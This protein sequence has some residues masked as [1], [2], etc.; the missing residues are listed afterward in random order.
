M[1]IWVFNCNFSVSYLS[2]FKRCCFCNCFFCSRFSVRLRFFFSRRWVFFFVCLICRFIIYVR[3]LFLFVREG[4]LWLLVDLNRSEG[5]YL[6]LVFEGGSFFFSFI[7]I[8]MFL[9]YRFV[10]SMAFFVS[11]RCFCNFLSFKSD[12]Y[13]SLVRLSFLS[14]FLIFLV[15]LRSF[16]WFL[17]DFR[18]FLAILI[19]FVIIVFWRDNLFLVFFFWK[20]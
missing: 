8:L 3:F 9:R 7:K 20:F 11:V 15:S 10:F 5:V 18:R 13:F 2:F 6:L 17:C 12:W 16:F 19:C 1:L 14:V 4:V